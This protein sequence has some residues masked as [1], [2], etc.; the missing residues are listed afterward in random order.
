MKIAI[1][2][3]RSFQDYGLLM[4]TMAK[5]K[6]S[7]IVSGGAKGA[8]TLAERYAGEIGVDCIIFKPDWKR[9]GRAA[10][11][12]RNKQIVEAADRIIAFWNGK[13]RGTFS[14]ITLAMKARKPVDVVRFVEK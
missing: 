9:Y 3:S 13:S 11:P 4:K 10:G 14:T 8:D 2:G 5:H 1:V 6:P 7:A 12:K